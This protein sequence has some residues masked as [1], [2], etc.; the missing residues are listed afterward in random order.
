[1]QNVTKKL[2]WI[3]WMKAISMYLII[4]GHCNVPGAKYIWVFCVPCFFLISGFL[5]KKENDTNIFVKKILW[6]LMAPMALLYLLDLLW[7]ICLSMLS[8]TYETE[9][10]WHRTMNALMGYHGIGHQF[11]GLGVLWFV[12]TLIICKILLQL[13]PKTKEVFSLSVLSIIMLIVSV[14]F[15]DVLANKFNAVINVLLAFPFFSIGYLLKPIKNHLPL[16]NYWII[17]VMLI[18]GIIG[19]G[20]CGKNNEEVVFFNCSYGSNLLL[21][22]LG[23]IS[24]TVLVFAVSYLCKSQLNA[25][26]SIMGGGTLLVLGL[27]FNVMFLISYF[28]TFEG[29]WRYLE[30]LLV[31]L[32]FIPFIVFVKRYISVLYGKYRQ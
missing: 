21:C 18:F 30:A 20:F 16:I 4:A 6:N 10:I 26:I 27:Q 3:D 8:G 25:V 31:Y 23:G 1:M 29:Y 22:L 11:Y 19:V 24:G 9:M 32:L 13:I 17:S 14:A 5:S 2:T 12:Y 7:S 15:N 28:I